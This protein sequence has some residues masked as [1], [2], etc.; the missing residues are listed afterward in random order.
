ML[1]LLR[2]LLCKILELLL[3]LLSFRRSLNSLVLLSFSFSV[4]YSSITLK[5]WSYFSYE[6]NL[7]WILNLLACV[8][9]KFYL[10]LYS[11]LS[12]I[13]FLVWIVYSFYYSFMGFIFSI[14]P[15]LFCVFRLILLLLLSRILLLFINLVMFSLLVSFTM[16]FDFSFYKS[17]RPPRL[18]FDRFELSSLLLSNLLLSLL[19]LSILLLSSRLLANFTLERL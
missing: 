14:S 3:D 7:F 9:Y 16:L 15:S 17:W 19:L 4:S 18:L 12:L 13:F 10:P 2:F 6:F 5:C 11:V 1:P 8:V